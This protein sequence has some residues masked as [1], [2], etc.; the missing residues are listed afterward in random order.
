MDKNKQENRLVSVAK[1]ELQKTQQLAES[2]YVKGQLKEFMN[3]KLRKDIVIRDDLL[4]GGAEP[5]L[6]LTDKID[7]RQKALDDLVSIIDTHQT[8]L[9]STYDVAKAAI[10]KLRRY[11]PKKANELEN[12]LAL[13]VKQSGSNTIKKKRL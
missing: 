2:D 12:S 11:N 5:S 13:K 4:K 3:N 8:H 10:S 9:L 7:G 1:N 6:K